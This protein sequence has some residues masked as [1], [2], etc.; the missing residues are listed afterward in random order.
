MYNHLTVGKQ[1]TL[2]YLNYFLKSISPKVN[3]I[4]RLGF[5]LAYCAIAAECVNHNATGTLPAQYNINLKKKYYE[6]KIS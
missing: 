6:F 2:V 4:A 1:I 5:E 3:V